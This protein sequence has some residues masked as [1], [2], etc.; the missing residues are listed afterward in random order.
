MK[1]HDA[2]KYIQNKLQKTIGTYAITQS[3]EILEFFLKCPRTDLYIK[4]D[5]PIPTDIIP[6]IDKIIERR[7]NGEPLQYILGKTFFYSRD[8]L[9]TPDVLI[10]R[11]DTETLV[12]Q[13]FKYEKGKNKYFV[14]IGTG[15]GII[16]SIL[17]DYNPGWKGIAID[18]SYKAL[19]IARQNIK[20]C[21]YL[22]CSDLMSP[23]KEQKKFD[24]IVSNPPYIS[25]DELETLDREVKDFEPHRALFGGIDGLDFYSLL[26]ENAKKWLKPGGAIY[27]EIGYNQEPDVKKLFS[28]SNCAFLS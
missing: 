26:S 20:N 18:I 3:E 9:I 12:E 28:N 5:K 14:D 23:L 16:A 22:L 19:L 8:F 25:A 24:F 11:P 17:T 27:C 1:I 10:P 13:V 21:V 15:S 6:E 2:L 4:S 7:L